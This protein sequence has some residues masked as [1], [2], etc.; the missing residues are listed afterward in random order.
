MRASNAG[1]R[2]QNRNDDKFS[3]VK[4]R[5]LQNMTQD[6][7]VPHMVNQTGTDGYSSFGMNSNLDIHSNSIHNIDQYNNIYIDDG[8]T[9]NMKM[10]GPPPRKNMSAIRN[11]N[12]IPRL[13]NNIKS[14]INKRLDEYIKSKR[15]N[16]TINHD[17]RPLARP[18]SNMTIDCN[19]FS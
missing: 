7:D 12:K 16:G 14:K 4:N 10:V 9:Y 19:Y 18:N 1:H 5:L 17:T 2:R 6:I 13:K 3:K 8:G 15:A 11:H